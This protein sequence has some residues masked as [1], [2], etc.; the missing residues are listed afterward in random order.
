[1]C[2][3][4]EPS[5]LFVSVPINRRCTTTTG[6]YSAATPSE[7]I[8]MLRVIDFDLLVVGLDDPKFAVWEFLQRALAVWSEQRW[9][10]ASSR[11]TTNDEVLARSRGALLVLDILPDDQWLVEFVASLRRRDALRRV[12]PSVSVGRRGQSLMT[13]DRQP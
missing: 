5:L 9:I 11:V 13:A 12:R 1:M 7:A 8:A 10:L 6:F 4:T 3:E 2:C